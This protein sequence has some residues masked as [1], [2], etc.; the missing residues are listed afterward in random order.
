MLKRL[1]KILL[2]LTV[3]SIPFYF[4]RF[5]IG[6]VPTTVLEILIYLTFITALLS[7]TLK[8]LVNNNKAAFYFG[9]IFVLAALF[10][11]LNDPNRVNALGLFKA[12]FFD[13][14]L[15]MCVI[16]Q[17][18]K[19]DETIKKTLVLSAVLTGLAALIIFLSG[20]QT[21]D[22]RLLDLERLSPNY[23]A[24]FLSPVLVLSLALGFTA[25][26]KNWFY[27]I[28]SGLMLVVLF[29]TGS[30]GSILA[31]GGG[32]IVLLASALIAR[33]RGKI[34]RPL[35]VFALLA[36]LLGGYAV[37]KP[38]W[39]SHERKA[40]SSNIRYHIWT[41]S[42]EIIGKN[43]AKG[44]GLSNYQNYFSTLTKDR[45]NFPEFISPE[46]LTA[47]NLYLQ[48]FVV[49]GFALFATFIL[50]ILMSRFWTVQDL[51]YVA[52]LTALLVYALVD[53]PFF[54]NDLSI[55]FWLILAILYASSKKTKKVQA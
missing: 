21:S 20:I 17:S 1:T 25:W 18:V 55:V 36:L 8:G 2:V 33:G 6:P 32:V 53:T 35:L 27:L 47:H 40:T 45:V 3:F 12:Y 51:S 42:L 9:F 43:P 38:D 30:R 19:Q 31:V 13:G 37:Y 28:G 24:M 49:G 22:G 5:N 34:A 26:P 39:T 54:R 50:W 11:A 7:G 16:V 48:F 29:L 46:A 52:A 15:L 23:L 44:V 41:T 14:F 4:W 10:A